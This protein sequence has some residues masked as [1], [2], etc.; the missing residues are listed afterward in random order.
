MLAGNGRATALRP[1]LFEL[2]M[3]I[4]ATPIGSITNAAPNCFAISVGSDAGQGCANDWL[5]VSA[6]GRVK[7]PVIDDIGQYFPSD[8]KPV[9]QTPPIGWVGLG[10]VVI[11]DCGLIKPRVTISLI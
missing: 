4:A 1:L 3:D 5:I 6:K 8:A 11:H 2:R 9:F 10:T 7:T